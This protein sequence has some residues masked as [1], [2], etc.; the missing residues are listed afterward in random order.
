[1]LS[2][3]QPIHCRRVTV[4]EFVR[5][6]L[7][8]NF[9]EPPPFDLATSFESTDVSTPLVFILSPGSDP[10]KA[11]LNFADQVPTRRGRLHRHAPGVCVFD[12]GTALTVASHACWAARLQVGMRSK[13]EGVSLGKGQGALAAKLI[14]EAKVRGKWV[15]L[16]VRYACRSCH[17]WDVYRFGVSSHPRLLLLLE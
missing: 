4:Q 11:F 9:I 16:Q 7:G 3:S 1:M 10:F 12:P 6:H 14:E 5:K 15:L 17:Q 2:L 8:P 13:I